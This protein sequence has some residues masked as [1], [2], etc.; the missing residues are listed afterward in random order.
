MLL[1]LALT[2]SV[3]ACNE[4]SQN[5]P[6]VR[7]LNEQN[8]IDILVGSCIQSTRNCDP[9]QSIVEVKKALAAGEV[10]RL[11]QAKDI[12]TEDMVIAVF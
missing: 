12:P 6:E 8:L 7:T 3:A 2:L 1:I 5:R 4:V 11:I 9:S 10:F